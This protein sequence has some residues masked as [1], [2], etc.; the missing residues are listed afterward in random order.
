MKYFFLGKGILFWV[1]GTFRHNV[2][3]DDDDGNITNFFSVVKMTMI[4]MME[5]SLCW[6]AFR[7]SIFIDNTIILFNYYL[8]RL[9]YLKMYGTGCSSMTFCKSIVSQVR[10]SG[11]VSTKILSEGDKRVDS[12][13]WLRLTTLF[14]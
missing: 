14:A 6:L 11:F 12:L 13:K 2:G 9:P 4:I 10:A 3:S 5:K 7:R 8:R 1:S